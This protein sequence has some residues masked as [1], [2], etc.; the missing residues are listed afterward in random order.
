[1]SRERRRRPVDASLRQDDRAP[2]G[3]ALP[4]VGERQCQQILRIAPGKHVVAPVALPI[5]RADAGD[6][7]HAGIGA[8]R[9]RRVPDSRVTGEDVDLR[10]SKPGAAP[11]QGGE[12]RHG[13]GVGDRNSRDACHPEPAA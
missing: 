12:G 10:L 13:R 4:Y 6:S 7:V 3:R 1:M 8:R 5:V 2:G 11:A 9:D